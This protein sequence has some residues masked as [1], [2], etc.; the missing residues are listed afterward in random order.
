MG[1][2]AHAEVVAGDVN[3]TCEVERA[4]Q[5]KSQQYQYRY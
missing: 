5:L 4:L 3:V 1:D 2:N